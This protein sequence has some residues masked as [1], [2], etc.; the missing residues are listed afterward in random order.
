MKTISLNYATVTQGHAFLSKHKPLSVLLCCFH[1]T[2]SF[3]LFECGKMLYGQFIFNSFLNLYMKLQQLKY[4]F[5]LHLIFFFCPTFG[6]FLPLMGIF[7]SV[8]FFFYSSLVLFFYISVDCRV[9]IF[10]IIWKCKRLVI[11]YE[12]LQKFKKN[13]WASLSTQD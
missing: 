11:Y 12:E 10:I 7:K 4:G 5:F 2:Y 9:L 13:S 3:N 8:Q 6:Y 1:L